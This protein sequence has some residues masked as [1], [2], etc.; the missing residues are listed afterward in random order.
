MDQINTPKEEFLHHQEILSGIKWRNVLYT[1][2]TAKETIAL[3][4]THVPK[5][6]QAL[7]E[8]QVAKFS[9]Y[10]F[11]VIKV[12]QWSVSA[13]Q[14]LR[15]FIV[16]DPTEEISKF[17]QQDPLFTS[18]EESILCHVEHL[19][20]VVVDRWAGH[21][22]FKLSLEPSL[23]NELN[24]QQYALVHMILYVMDTWMATANL[25]IASAYFSYTHPKYDRFSAK[26]PKESGEGLVMDT[27]S[28]RRMGHLLNLCSM[29]HL[30]IEDLLLKPQPDYDLAENPNDDS[31][32]E[33]HFPF[34]EDGVTT[35][36]SGMI[37]NTM[38]PNHMDSTFT[39]PL[40][41]SQVWLF[42]V[43]GGR[44][45]ASMLKE[46]SQY[47]LTDKALA[48]I[49]Y[50]IDRLPANWFSEESIE[51]KTKESD[52][53]QR[54]LMN[55][56]MS[57]VNFTSTCETAK[58]RFY[59]YQALDKLM[60]ACDD[61]LKVY[62][63]QQCVASNC[64]YETMRAAGINLVKSAVDKAYQRLEKKRKEMV[65]R[66]RRGEVKEKTETVKLSPFT[67]HELL[68]FFWDPIWGVEATNGV[69]DACMNE[70]SW[71][72]RY[73]RYMYGLNFYLYLLMRDSKEENLTGVW[74]V[75]NL[76][77]MQVEFVEPLADRAEVLLEDF[78]ER[79]ELLEK[80]QMEKAQALSR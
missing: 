11:D 32:T 42:K 52:I 67:C 14:N 79:I 13:T 20:K 58:H 59:A 33:E 3:F 37:Y 35:L 78:S 70:Q 12:L 55:V 53:K 76:M 68:K 8:I 19:V 27:E 64:P 71:L 16:K 21:Q 22:T 30:S 45:T 48:V 63:L 51:Y 46:A 24:N 36:V 65:G 28:L 73:D 17:A 54:G 77:R 29:C 4:N 2:R 7:S 6:I 10:I 23:S 39:L 31:L 66:I 40:A 15:N 50:T 75:S 49:L 25:E 9:R 26:G 18:F 41:L 38:Y 34:S 5:L 56:F 80:A 72:D 61:D 43:A 60:E 57:T 62:F 44:A 47:E 69:E 74:T 1:P